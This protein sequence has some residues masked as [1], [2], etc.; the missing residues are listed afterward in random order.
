MTR[1]WL[2]LMIIGAAAAVVATIL[3]AAREWL[4]V[5][6]CLDRGGAFDYAEQRYRTDVAVLPVPAPALV[7]VPDAGSLSPRCQ[8]SCRTAGVTSVE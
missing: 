1:W 5:D 3:P 7:R 6:R 2:R 8:D 4:A